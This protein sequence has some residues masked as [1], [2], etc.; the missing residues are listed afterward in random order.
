MTNS[1]SKPSI[2]S[3]CAFFFLVLSCLPAFAV[4]G[5]KYPFTLLDPTKTNSEANP[6]INTAGKVTYFEELAKYEVDMVAYGKTSTRKGL[7]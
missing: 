6:F 3:L 2:L 7:V 4:D 1:F 5:K